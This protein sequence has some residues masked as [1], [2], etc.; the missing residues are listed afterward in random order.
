MWLGVSIPKFRAK[1]L[2]KTSNTHTPYSTVMAE[3]GFD[4]RRKSKEF[5]CLAKEN[6]KNEDR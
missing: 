2:L 3:N 1:K 4:R 6:G 5:G